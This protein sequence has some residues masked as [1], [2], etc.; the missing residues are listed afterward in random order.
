MVLPNVL[1]IESNMGLTKFTISRN[2]KIDPFAYIDG[3][4]AQQITEDLK[5]ILNDWL[6]NY[7]VPYGQRENVSEKAIER[8]RELQEENKL[9]FIKPFQSPIF[10]W[11]QYEKSG[12]AKPYEHS[13]PAL[14]DYLARLIAKHNIFQELGGIK[15][16]IANNAGSY[17]ELITNPISLGSKGLFSLL[18]DIEIITFPSLSQPLIKI[19][20]H[21][22]RWLSSLKDNGFNPNDINGYIFSKKHSDRVFN[23]KLNRRNNLNTNQWEWQPDSAFNV[24]QRELNL[25]LHISNAKQIVKG[26]AS[27][28][29]CQ[30]LLTYRDGIQQ[31][32]HDIKAGVPEKDKLEAFKAIA[33]ILAFTG[34]KPFD[35]YSKVKFGKGKGHT[36]D[37]SASRTINTPTSFSS[38]LESL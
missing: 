31:K 7:L 20:V 25:P 30:V 15:R 17:I 6:E 2:S 19:D 13:F 12:T 3:D 26:E 16:I 14:V 32:K 8:L 23:F 5:S 34:I 9:L 18:I 29:D 22:R 24:L 11:L 10:P 1:R 28:D 21:K 27:T 37:I 38:I 35:G 36:Q 33:E 4:N